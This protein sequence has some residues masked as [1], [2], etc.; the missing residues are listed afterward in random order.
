MTKYLIVD[1]HKSKVLGV[2]VFRGYAKLSDLA[3]ISK[4]DIFDAKHNPTGT[5]R[6]LNSKHA[7]EAYEY[8]KNREL[9]FWP[10]VFL[11]VRD[12][13][14][15][16]FK[17]DKKD[18]EFGQLRIN[19][20]I[21]KRKKTISISRVDGNHRLHYADGT[22]NGFE[23]INKMVSFCLATELTLEQEI[24]LF[25]DINNNQRRMNTSHLDNIEVRLSHDDKLKIEKTDLYIAQKLG[26]DNNSP[27]YGMVYPGGKKS[28]GFTI[29]LRSLK[30]GINYLL[31]QTKRLKKLKDGEAQYR[32]VKNYFS[33]LR[34]WIPEAW[35]KPKEYL[36]LRGAGLWASCFI[37]AEVIEICLNEGKFNVDDMLKLLK[38]GK[39]WD[40]SNKGKFKGYS[41][42]GGATEISNVVSSEFQKPGII[43]DKELFKKIMGD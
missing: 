11:C 15:F 35:A 40:W 19:I 26:E 7:K 24:T 17:R 5:Q 22:E 29:P 18:S 23:P 36:L 8:V 9:A 34:K 2:T 21:A 39:D 30:T 28:T 10:E 37:G 3:S 38:S 1:A 6:D 12:K 14:V 13:K 25:R 27:F 42:R 41:G 31:S 16:D 4:P 20:S 32:V 43:S 33:A